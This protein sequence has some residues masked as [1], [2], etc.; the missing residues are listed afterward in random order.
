M[1]GNNN[2]DDDGARANSRDLRSTDTAAAGCGL[3]LITTNDLSR[4]TIIIIIEL[5]VLLLLLLLCISIVWSARARAAKRCARDVKALTFPSSVNRVR[6]GER[7]RLRWQRVLAPQPKLPGATR[8]VIIRHRTI[9]ILRCYYTNAH[10][11]K[12]KNVWSSIDKNKII[13][14]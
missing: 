14:I 1:L 9:I 5:V 4:E 6:V 10:G 12:K 11:R 2:T 13:I 7:T 3:T 8:T